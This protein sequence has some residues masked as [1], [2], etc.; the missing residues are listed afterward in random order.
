MLSTT[1]GVMVGSGVGVASGSLEEQA[2][3]VST[4]APVRARAERRIFF[5]ENKT[6]F[7]NSYIPFDGGGAKKFPKIF[8][9]KKSLKNPKEGFSF[10]TNDGKI[11]I[12]ATGSPL[13]GPAFRS[14]I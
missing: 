10:Q 11:N 8:A 7:L 13:S 4:I 12:Y 2:A 9:R 1:L 5:I 6:P 3:R 14:Y